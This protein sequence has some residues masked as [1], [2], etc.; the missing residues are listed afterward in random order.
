MFNR[1]KERYY[2]MH[3]PSTDP[4]IVD[5]EFLQEIQYLISD[6]KASVESSNIAITDTQTKID[7]I[8]DSLGI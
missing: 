8:A 6:I 3:K 5:I 1:K 2:F 4:H 7:S